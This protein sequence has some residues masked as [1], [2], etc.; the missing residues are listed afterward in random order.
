MQISSNEAPNGLLYLGFN[1]DQT[2]FAC[3]MSNGYR[4][5]STDPLKEQK[6]PSPREGGFRIVELFLRSNYVALVGGGSKP[7]FPVN[8]VVIWDDLK[9]KPVSNLKFSSEVKSV[10]LRR[11]RIVVVLESLIKVYTFGPVPQEKNIFETCNNPKGMYQKVMCYWEISMINEMFC[12]GLCS[13]CPQDNNSLLAF[14]SRKTGHITLADFINTEKPHTDI[15]AH[16]SPLSCMS[17]NLPGTRL[18]TASEKGT[19]IRVFDTSS[20]VML[21]ELRRGANQ[22]SI[23]W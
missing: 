21:N 2:C 20:G 18:A 14:P 1:Q 8:E 6:K 9:S 13:L 22:A 15:A 7:L 16:K 10:K 11:D 17:L 3:G 4:V 5:Y 19:L 23:Y 12:L